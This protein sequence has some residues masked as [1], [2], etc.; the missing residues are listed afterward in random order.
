MPRA[1]PCSCTSVPSTTAP[2]CGSTGRHVGSHEG[3]HT[4]F[5]VAARPAPASDSGFEIVVRAEDDP[6][7]L[8][9][10][11]GKQDWRAEPHVIW[12]H[13]TTGIWQP[14]WLESVPRQHL[15]RAR[16]ATRRGERPG[17]PDPRAGR[18]PG[19]ARPRARHPAA[20]VSSSSPSSP[21]PWP[22][23]SS[24]PRSRSRR[25]A[26]SR[27]GTNCCGGPTAPRSSTR[28]S[29]SVA[30]GSADV[31]SSYLG[32]RVSRDRRRRV[33][34]QQRGP[35]A[36]RGVL[37]QGYW[38]QSHL[39]APR[40]R[41]C[42]PRSNSSRSSASTP[43]ACTRRSK[44]RGSCTGPTASACSCGTRCRARS[45]TRTPPSRAC[46]REW[47]EV[48][49][50][51]SSHPSVVAWVPLNESWAVRQIARRSTRQQA[52]ART[53]Y[54]LTKTL[55]GTRPVIS[56]DGWE[57]TQ[58]DLLTI[59]DYE[60]DHEKLTERYGT[61]DA[62]AEAL[63]GISPFGK[64]DAGRNR[65]GGVGD[66]IRPCHAQRIRRR[67]LHARSRGRRV[68]LPA[69]RHARRSGPSPERHLRRPER[70]HRARRMG[71]HAAH[72][73]RPRDQRPDRREPRAQAPADRIREIVRGD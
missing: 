30:G 32:L 60:N 12:Y 28:A 34:A 64:R 42:A 58:S 57:H 62:V 49:R 27:G 14:V 65:R 31:V 16:L 33:P 20:S 63:V 6:H 48:I 29:S 22:A 19:R 26:P 4:P 11:R 10:P 15:T 38:P 43:R 24:T 9:Q 39:A 41:R 36:I 45:S 51:D 55:D 7:D 13:R 61:P 71:L 69:R 25:S 68:G 35:Y 73:H 46:T 56:N 17:P 8:S 18:A 23:P 5:T 3:G 67:E 54:H 72:R 66:G 47:T 37:S 52:F 50:R 21:S 1:G 70:Q 59:H 44:T 40:R 53:L 2:T